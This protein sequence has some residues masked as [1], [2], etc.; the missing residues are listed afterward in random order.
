MIINELIKNS[1]ISIN[2]SLKNKKQIHSFLFE[3]T[4]ILPNSALTKLKNYIEDED[5]KWEIFES[6]DPNYKNLL[7]TKIRK[8]KRKKITSHD[9]SIIEELQLALKSQTQV[10]SDIVG[11][12][13]DFMG[14]TLWQDLE[15][16]DL[17]WH[18]DNKILKATLQI[19]LFGVNAP[20]TLFKVDDT[21]HEVVFES[22]HGYLSVQNTSGK[23]QHKIKHTVTDKRYSL[24]VMWS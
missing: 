16:F 13:L 6:Y 14:A 2:E 3:L 1:A 24:F 15:G 19:Y 21:E 10:I 11:E 22:N 18:T 9:D 5:N 4:D 17:A 8:Q 20:G 7:T 12:N 23:L